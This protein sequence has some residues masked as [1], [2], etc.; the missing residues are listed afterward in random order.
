MKLANNFKRNFEF[1]ESHPKFYLYWS[2]V[3]LVIFGL[4]GIGPLIK[5]LI[6][7]YSASRDISSTTVRLEE[8]SAELESHRFI[9]ENFEKLHPNFGVYLPEEPN[10]E[11]YMVDFVGK[12]EAGGFTVVSFS[13]Q[14]NIKDDG[15]ILDILMEGS[16]NVPA[17]VSSVESLKR[18][19]QVE[20]VSF[21][22][23]K[24]VNKVRVIV[25]IFSI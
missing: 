15:I 12:A 2:L 5:I 11:D 16:G 25:K 14:R 24:G 4:L 22:D 7:K 17:L 3:V 20:E 13:P 9:L 23:V 18:L 8:K 21:L 10:T 1:I 19:S 6:V